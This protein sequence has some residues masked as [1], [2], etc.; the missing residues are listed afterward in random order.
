MAADFMPAGSMD[1]C[2]SGFRRR[3]AQISNKCLVLTAIDRQSF[4]GKPAT[5]RGAIAM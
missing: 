3:T 4:I 1:D 2:H 5:K